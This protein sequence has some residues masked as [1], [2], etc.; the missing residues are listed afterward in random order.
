MNLQPDQD[1]PLVSGRA[2]EVGDTGLHTNFKAN[3]YVQ[4]KLGPE[5]KLRV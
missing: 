3:L 2:M 4:R 5:P 1:S